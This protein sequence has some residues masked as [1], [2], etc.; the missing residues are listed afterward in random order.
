MPGPF[1]GRRHS[2]DSLL[3]Q[4]PAGM[5]ATGTSDMKNY[6]GRIQSIQELEP[7]PAMV[8]LDECIIRPA[9]GSRDEA[10]YYEWAPLDRC[11]KRK[12]QTS[13]RQGRIPPV[14]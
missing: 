8:R 14:R 10:I 12:G 3:G 7:T 4:S 13:S 9:T 11:R 5:N 6:H 2:R 1:Q